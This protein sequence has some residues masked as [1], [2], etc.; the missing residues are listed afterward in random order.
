VR[1]AGLLLKFQRNTEFVSYKTQQ[2]MPIWGLYYKTLR[3][4][5]LRS[6]YY[7]SVFVQASESD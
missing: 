3:N 2:E 6:S 1:V 7:A 4:R 5:N